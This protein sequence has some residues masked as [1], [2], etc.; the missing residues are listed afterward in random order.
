MKREFGDASTFTVDVVDQSGLG[1]FELHQHVYN[2]NRFN[3]LLRLDSYQSN[4]Q[5]TWLE[6]RWRFNSLA[7]AQLQTSDNKQLQISVVRTFTTEES[8]RAA[9]ALWVECVRSDLD[10]AASERI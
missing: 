10:V 2:T 8:A 3:F 1:S 7:G 9:F 6:Y 4:C 5:R